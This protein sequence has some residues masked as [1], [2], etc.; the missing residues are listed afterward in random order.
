MATPSIY[1]PSPSSDIAI[2]QGEI[3]TDINQYWLN[4]TTISEIDKKFN[5]YKHEY[6]IVL[7]QGCDLEQDFRSRLQDKPQLP[8][9][10]F[11]QVYPAVS[12]KSQLTGQAKDIWKRLIQ[13][14][15]ER[16]H[17]LEKIPPDLDFQKSGL[18][19][20]GIDFK[21]YF[22]IPTEEVYMCIKLGITR[23]RTILQS[24]YLEHLSSRFAYFLSRV[25][26]PTPHVSE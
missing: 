10:I 23:R 20:L 9:I 7:S 6:A 16:Y 14:K 17:Y 15:D 12:L 22:S 3:L 11:C 24:P 21:R 18:P 5:E 1:E 25:G 4:L 13:N 2:C 8:N 19:E 26:L